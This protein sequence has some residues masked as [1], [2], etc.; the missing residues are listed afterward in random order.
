MGI[1]QSLT[2]L[3]KALFTGT[4]MK[5]ADIT[6]MKQTGS[7]TVDYYKIHLDNVYITHVTN[8]VDNSLQ[9]VFQ[10]EL[11]AAKITWTNSYQKPDGS[12][13]PVSFGW[14]VLLK[15]SF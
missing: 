11:D 8:S 15:K 5:S 3:K 2:Y 14:D 7:S 4:A 6:F 12:Y 1:N 13:T 10:V 9:P